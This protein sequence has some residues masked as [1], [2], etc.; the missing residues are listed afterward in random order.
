MSTI[1]LTGANGFVG[2]HVLPA[3]VVAGHDVV[4]LVRA[5][6]AADAVFAGLEP[7]DHPRVTARLGDV[8]QP[9]TLPAAV[10]GVDAIAHLVA[11]PRDFNGGRDLAQV[12]TEGTRNI[13]RAA[14][15]EGV[16]RFIHLGAL[17]VA[18]DPRL[19]YASSKARAEANVRASAL[20]WTILKPSLLWGEG[21][22][23]FG[24]IAGLVRFSPGIV[25]VPGD[26]R[27]RFQPLWVGDLAQVMVLSLERPETIRQSYD[28]G[29]PAYWT[30]REITREVLGALGK[31]RLVLPM[32]VPL[33]SIVARAS[34]L[35]HLPFPVATDQ[36]RQLK[37]DNI[38]PVDGVERAF[39]IRPRPMNGRLGYLRQR[40]QRQGR[41]PAGTITE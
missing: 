2:S 11:I 7:R 38:G 17:G 37:L 15:T 34:E 1:L 20:D 5:D 9:D 30:Y 14:E 27:S 25:P 10:A 21:D 22:G 28:L 16:R 6:A 4:P 31:R 13:V 24:L 39:G 29:G 3:L 40:G 35:V 23:F 32:P 18:D 19:H 41:R 33:I 8:T 12:N 36:L 26:G